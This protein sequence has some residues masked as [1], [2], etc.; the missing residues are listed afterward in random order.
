MGAIS[1]RLPDA[2]ERQLAR[3]AELAGR[4]RSELIR[5]ALA[6]FVA[7]QERERFLAQY[8][9]EAR[10]AYRNPEIRREA[11]E[12]AEDFLPAENAAADLADGRQPGEPWEQDERWWV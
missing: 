12:L 6:Q 2:L 9:A 5:D 11:L 8:V 1:L 3:E 4:S 10:A 7:Q